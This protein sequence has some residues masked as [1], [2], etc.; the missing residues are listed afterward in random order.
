MNITEDEGN[1]FASL[2][3]CSVGALP[4][5]YPSVPLHW[6]KLIVSIGISLLIR[7]KRNCKDEKKNYCLLVIE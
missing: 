6:K 5:F 4:I 2:F 1:R 7:L 3:G